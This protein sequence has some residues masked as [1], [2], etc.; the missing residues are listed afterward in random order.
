MSMAIFTTSIIV[1]L[2]LLDHRICL[3]EACSMCV[4]V[5][6]LLGEIPTL[7]DETALRSDQNRRHIGRMLEYAL[8]I[9]ISV[10]D[11][12]NECQECGA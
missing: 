9:C 11:V 7:T 3:C 10:F 4:D 8:A 12:S 5:E 2:L 6:L 1:R